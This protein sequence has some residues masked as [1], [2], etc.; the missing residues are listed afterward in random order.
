MFLVGWRATVSPSCRWD[1]ASGPKRVK[2]PRPL[3]K[4]RRGARALFVFNGPL[5]AAMKLN[6]ARDGQTRAGDL[7]HPIAHGCPESRRCVTRLQLPAFLTTRLEKRVPQRRLVT[8]F[9][10]KA[11]G[12]FEVIP[13]SSTT[14][15]SGPPGLEKKLLN[16]IPGSS[17]HPKT[18]G[19]RFLDGSGP[20]PGDQAGQVLRFADV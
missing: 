16:G 12:C 2:R 4:A 8:L 10:S 19:K 17:T 9:L 15:R 11:K 1:Q 13:G 5:Q 20:M 3:R 7:D 14:H 18:C 6:C